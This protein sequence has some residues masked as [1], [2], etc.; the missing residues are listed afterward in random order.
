MN[1]G[2][3]HYLLDGFPHTRLAN[4]GFVYKQALELSGYAQQLA[5]GIRA[6]MLS[7]LRRLLA[8]SPAPSIDPDDR[9]LPSALLFKSA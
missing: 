9:Q 4:S 1:M 8:K 2:K 5:P 6:Q 7:C 3:V